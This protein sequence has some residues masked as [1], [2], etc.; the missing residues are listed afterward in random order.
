[1][2]DGQNGGIGDIDYAFSHIGL[3]VRDLE[4]T[5]RFW[6]DGLG[7]EKAEV[8]D[9]KGEFGE[10]LEVEGDVDVT[11]QFIRKGAMAIE[12]LHYASPGVVGEP[13]MRRN[14]L[15]LTHVSV[16]VDDIDAAAAHLVACGGTVLDSTRT[17]T[18]DPNA[19]HILFL[20]DPDGT[21]VELL[22]YP[23]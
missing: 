15:G 23:G 8:Y 4:R 13:S 2:S 10:A 12:L 11:S 22:R 5:L 18:D 9:I 16:V 20:A 7:F 21:R 3:C 6:C 1:M 19:V 14:Q 17:G